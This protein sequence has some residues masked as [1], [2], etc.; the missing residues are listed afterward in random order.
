LFDILAVR[1][2][3]RDGYR[4]NVQITRT[5][6]VV[7]WTNTR[8]FV[9]EVAASDQSLPDYRRLVRHRMRGEHTDTVH[10]DSA[11]KYQTSF[12]VEI[13]APELFAQVHDE[14]LSD[15]GKRGLL[16]NFHP[17]HRLALAPLGYVSVEARR[18]CILFSAFHTFP[19]EYTVI[20]TQS[21]IETRP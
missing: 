7:T 19:N 6:H 20:K 12:Q 4:L 3:E 18:G 13:L 14:I 15:G 21:L 17:N 2:V 5:G 1:T 10:I 8:A 16:H 9:T 11:V